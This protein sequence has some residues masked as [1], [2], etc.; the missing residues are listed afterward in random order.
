MAVDAKQKDLNPSIASICIENHFTRKKETFSSSAEETFS[1]KR[2]RYKDKDE[3]MKSKAIKDFTPFC[4]R[5][6]QQ[7]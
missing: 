7:I 4:Y 3:E 6:T 5:K 1:E 2:D